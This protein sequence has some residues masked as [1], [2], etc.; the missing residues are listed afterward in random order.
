M[1]KN[2]LSKRKY[3]C[4]ISLI[5]C[6][7]FSAGTIFAQSV[8]ESDAQQAAKFRQEKRVREENEKAF[9]D[10]KRQIQRVTGSKPTSNEVDE[11]RRDTKKSAEAKKSIEARREQAKRINA[12]RA[13]NPIDLE[14]YEEFLMQPNT[15]LFRLFPDLDCE[16]KNVVRVD[17]D[18]ENA[19]LFSSAYS[20]RQKDYVG[21][22]FLDVRLKDGNLIA[23]GFLSQE[24]LLWLGDVSLE[25][26]SLKSSGI[27]FLSEFKPEPK[28]Q[29][30]KKQFRKIAKTIES[31]GHKYGK[32]AKIY[33]NNTYAARIVA[34]RNDDKKIASLSYDKMSVNE[35]KFWDLK[36]DKRVDLTIAFR[37][38][39]QDENGSI[40]ILW[41]ELNRQ[42]A[43]KI[44]F[45]KTDKLTDIK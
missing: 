43:P 15:G 29:E 23:D 44:T 19:V 24:I 35:K 42:K 27:K 36:E 30:A 4:L 18:C 34:Y 11:I 38:V 33:V 32:S 14:K 45:A 12:L 1:I 26:V 37:V 21:T 13:P 8:L 9:D 2:N 6:I 20:F 28:I 16:T 17:G 5:I 31:E 41:K 22:D 3:E 40:T 7:L 25:N 10:A 39:R